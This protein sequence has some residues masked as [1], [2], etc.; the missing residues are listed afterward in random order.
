MSL[1]ADLTITRVLVSTRT[2]H[3]SA[4]STSIFNHQKNEKTPT[5]KATVQVQAINGNVYVNK[6][7]GDH[8]HKSKKTDI[9]ITV[10]STVCVCL[11]ICVYLLYHRLKNSRTRQSNNPT[12]TFLVLN[13]GAIEEDKQRNNEE[14]NSCETSSNRGSVPDLSSSLSGTEDMSDRTADSARQDGRVIAN[15]HREHTA[16]IEAQK[17]IPS[18]LEG[19]EKRSD[20]EVTVT[21]Q[22]TSTTELHQSSTTSISDIPQY[23]LNWHLSKRTSAILIKFRHKICMKLDTL[24]ELLCDDYRSLA[25]KIGLDRDDIL[26]LGQ[27][28]NKTEFILQK[29]D[30]QEDPSIRRFKEILEEMG[31]NDVVTVIDDW[32]LYEWSKQNDNSPSIL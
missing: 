27:Q 16:V 9:I 1:P 25:E 30:A 26:W 5:S 17:G 14:S 20:T 22:C 18:S 2:Q 23:F 13:R 3:I 12:V 10:L 4:M 32:V 31:R 29:F 24:R 7:N 15:Y 11:L 19:L 21:D 28:N 8:T 6:M